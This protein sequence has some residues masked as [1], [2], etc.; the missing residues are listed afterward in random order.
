MKFFSTSTKYLKLSPKL[1]IIISEVE[2]IYDNWKR[3][4]LITGLVF[5]SSLKYVNDLYLW[6]MAI[7]GTSQISKARV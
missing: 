4:N 1:F 2:Y 7:G 6:I 3:L 5:D